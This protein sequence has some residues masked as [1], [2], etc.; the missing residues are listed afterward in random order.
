MA[1]GVELHLDYGAVGTILRSPE[2]QGLVAGAAN[3]IASSVRGAARVYVDTYT[4]D[5]AAASVTIVEHDALER[6]ALVGRL[7]NAA[8][9]A[10]LDVVIRGGA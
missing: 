6:E 1:G 4:T 10:G 5:R 9:G 3:S 8:R 7:A 2:M